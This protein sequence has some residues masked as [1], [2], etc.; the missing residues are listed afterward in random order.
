MEQEKKPRRSKAMSPDQGRD[1]MNLIEFP[2]GPITASGEKTFEVEHEVFDR[3]LK[4]NVTRRFVITGSDRF[5]LPRPVD[6]RVLVGLTTLT[7]EAG[8]VSPR[9][10]FSGYHLCRTIGWEPDGRAYRRLEESF[11]RIAGTYLKFKDAWYDKGEKEYLSKG[12]HLIESF[13]LCTKG[14]LQRK[15][16]DTGQAELALSHFVWNDVVWKSFGDR[17]IKQVDMAL[18]RQIARGRKR[19]VPLRL[20]RLLDKRFHKK[21]VV[22]LGLWNLAV[23]KLGLSPGSP[24]ELLRPVERA[25]KVLIDCRYLERIR[26]DRGSK[27]LVFYRARKSR[28]KSTNRHRPSQKSSRPQAKRRTDDLKRWLAGQ[29]EEELLRFETAALSQGFGSTFERRR[30]AEDQRAGK[31][32]SKSGRVRQEYLRRFMALSGKNTAAA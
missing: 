22:R 2:F 1:E 13:E 16:A 23:E 15:R 32:I 29:A 9:V 6:E 28:T 4:R 21:S 7:F 25:A 18:F 11:D 17:F 30:V 26:Y 10:A 19:E 5:G 24:S 27:E 14:R 3:F 8:F 20:F 12:F 31:S